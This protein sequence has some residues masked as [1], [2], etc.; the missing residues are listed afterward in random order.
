MTPSYLARLLLLSSTAFFLVQIVVGALV[1][2]I[3]PAAIRRAATIRPRDAARWLLTLRLLPAAFATLVVA[4]LCVPSYLRFEPRVAGEEVGIA[5]VFAAILGAAIGA[6]GIY[7]ALGALVRSRRYLRRCGGVESS[8]EGEK[9]WI[10]RHSAGLALAGIVHPRLLISEPAWNDLPGDQLALALRHERAHRVSR[11][12]MKR[13]LLLLAPAIFPRLRA[14]E[15][16]WAR[17]SEWA[18]DDQAAEG[19][20]NRSLALAAALVRV[21]RLQS[22]IAMPP[23]VTSL[24]EAD[25]DLSL[26]VERLLHP[27]PL[28]EANLRPAAIAV[29]GVALLIAAS[30][31]NPAWLRLV[32]QLLERLL[33]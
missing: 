22:G 23:L 5:C 13:L 6:A 7:Q 9:V 33:D 4:A 14:L 18:A 27:A 28:N 3:A 19:D 30:A 15:S 17:C 21:A 10:V 25:E 16:A 31:M 26:R 29:S 20:A 11:D 12:N 8:V 1:A 24:V 2:S 32:H